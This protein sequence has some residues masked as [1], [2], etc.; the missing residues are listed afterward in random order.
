MT[1]GIP[2]ESTLVSDGTIDFRWRHH[3]LLRASVAQDRAAFMKE[4][5]DSV[6]N[7]PVSHP[8]LVDVIAQ[9]VSLWA[10]QFVSAFGQPFDANS[11]F[12]PGLDL[13]TIHP[14]QQRG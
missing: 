14:R 7:V 9:V 1:T 5:E 4:V 12:I 10:P 3:I 6:V 8:Q 2:N 11:A 13:Q